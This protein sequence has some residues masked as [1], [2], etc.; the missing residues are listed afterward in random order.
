ME[1]SVYTQQNIQVTNSAVVHIMKRYVSTGAVILAISTAAHGNLITNGSF[2]EPSMPK[3]TNVVT[4]QVGS[5]QFTGWEVV[6]PYGGNV[7]HAK[8]VYN[9]PGYGADFQAS[10]G[11]YWVDLTGYG[12]NAYQGISQN[13][14]ATQGN[15]LLTFEIGNLGD[16]KFGLGT[17]STIELRINGATVQAFTN[18]SVGNN[19]LN[20]QSFSYRFFADGLTSISFLNLDPSF[21]HQNALDNVVLTLDNVVPEA[22]PE[23]STYAL[24][25]T[26]VMLLVISANRKKNPCG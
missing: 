14:V 12:T 5:T 25:L 22:V 3:G 9:V 10:H 13:V 4:Y 1:H 17:S 7:D 16:P 20:W 15:Y 8:T 2:E 19:N 23:P 24:M 26:G 11:N 6:G 21:D 18:T